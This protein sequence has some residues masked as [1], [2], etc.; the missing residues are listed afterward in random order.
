VSYR[1]AH[2]ITCGK[3]MTQKGHSR[4][5]SRAPRGHGKDRELTGGTGARVRRKVA[6]VRRRT[7]APTDSGN[8]VE[9][10]AIAGG[11][12]MALPEA[13]IAYCSPAVHVTLIAILQPIIAGCRKALLRLKAACA[14]CAFARHTARLANAGA[15]LN[16][17][18]PAADGT[19]KAEVDNRKVDRFEPRGVDGTVC[20]AKV[21][22]PRIHH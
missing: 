15:A 18:H 12:A 1:D 8:A 20:A 4:G 16:A 22:V 2:T 6:K 7:I 13:R 14:T 21:P 5:Y 3:V 19:A 11:D 10:V 17:A 9:A